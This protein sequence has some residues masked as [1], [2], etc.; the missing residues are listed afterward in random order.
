MLPLLRYLVLW[1]D[2]CF[3]TS[4]RHV[5][6]LE[7]RLSE[8]E[9]R[10]GIPPGVA[11]ATNVQRNAALSPSGRLATAAIVLDD[12]RSSHSRQDEIEEAESPR[13]PLPRRQDHPFTQRDTP[14]YEPVQD[15]STYRVGDLNTA[16]P[17]QSLF[18][19]HRLPNG[20][21]NEHYD[22][23]RTYDLQAIL[24]TDTITDRDEDNLDGPDDSERTEHIPLMD[25]MVEY[26]DASSEA[27]EGHVFYGNTSTLHFA[28]NVQASAVDKDG[29]VLARNATVSQ[30]ESMNTRRQ[31]GAVPVRTITQ[32]LTNQDV[33]FE[34]VSFSS[35]YF[36]YLPRRHIANSLL[37]R[38]FTA[39]HPIWPFLL[40]GPTRSRYE[41][42]WSADR[43]ESE[44]WS[45]QLNLIFALG[46]E[47]WEDDL[48]G[49]L[50]SRPAIEA[51]NDFYLRAKTFVLGNAFN[52][53]SI[54]MLQTLLLLVQYQ[55]G[56]MQS[57]QCWLTIGH[58]TRMAQGL[59]LHKPQKQNTSMSPLE[60]ELRNR[61]WW[62]CFSL[63]R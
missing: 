29:G 28:M 13:R 61:L 21:G 10:Q 59:G 34:R 60:E 55:Q 36:Q 2:F 8:L 58:A 4:R 52:M 24:N 46:F 33:N 48:T 63:D 31:S 38:Y 14:A 53:S 54:S 27:P 9:S 15:Q 49:G 6:A 32:P 11:S 25:G 23:A 39:I 12:P 51:G 56:T 22:I 30:G 5:T 17:D 43:P 40:E 35:L 1:A 50:P 47:F 44:I 3:Y 16:D 41:D 57:E 45:A 62:G 19:E 7:R 18:H 37:E 20:A 26:Q 42:A